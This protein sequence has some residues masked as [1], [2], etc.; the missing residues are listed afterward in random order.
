MT[1]H[2]TVAER[3][4]M[5]RTQL[6]ARGIA[7]ARVLEAM[8]TVPRE[9]FVDE[10]HRASAYQD[11]PL[12]I[13]DGQTISQPYIVALMAE[14]AHIGPTDHVLEV[15]AGS[16][17]ASAVLSRVAGSVV[18]VERHRSLAAGA[19]ARLKALGYSNVAVVHGDGSL[20]CPAHAPFDAIVV[21]AGG[22]DVPQALMEQ[23]RIGGTLVIPVGHDPNTQE[24]LLVRRLGEHRY[25]R[26][27]L[28]SVRFVPLVGAGGWAIDP[29]PSEPAAVSGP[30]QRRNVAA[31]I[32]AHCEPLTDHESVALDELV[33]RVGDARVVLI[34]E[35]THG[36]SE[37]Y[38][39][40][41]RIT[42]E[43]IRQAGFDVVALEADWPDAAVLNRHVNARATGEEC[44]RAFDRFPQWMWR[45]L[46]TAEF[47][48]WL[49]SRHLR[50][51]RSD[52]RVLVCGLDLYGMSKAIASVLEFLDREHP[53]AAK[54][55]RERYACLS[56]WQHD[57]ATYGRATMSGLLETCE[58][59]AVAMLRDMLEL[60]LA[61]PARTGDPLF[62]AQRNAAVVRDAERYYRA[63]YWGSSE[64]WNLRD[65][66]M[67]ST[68]QAVLAH[69]GATSKAV[70][71]AHNSHVGDASA[72]EM[73]ERGETNLGE[74]ARRSWGQGAYL[75]GMG[76]HHGTV[77]A[78]AAW[79]A[80]MR[81]RT[82]LPSHPDSFERLCLDAGVGN[83]MLALR[84]AKGAA[85]R[86]MLEVPRLQRAVGVVY[87][88]ETEFLSHYL[89][90]SVAR[91]FDEWIWFT[92]T[93]AVTA[94][95]GGTEDEDPGTYPF[96][97]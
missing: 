56:P 58:D 47:L 20:G 64:S 91:Q 61:D 87:R 37:F 9:E 8:R 77:A 92:R 54:L 55:A 43:L 13:S 39:M 27:S 45:N 10:R 22:P 18:A 74:L 65:A 15:G 52:R 16:G 12:P 42:R 73:R 88:P 32:A 83:F 36:T 81:V 62:E 85:L 66:H 5:V 30:R 28:G 40:R 97:T 34:G 96:G 94:T 84:H 59:E 86:A 53:A 14:A 90:A 50:L 35:S 38:R 93:S 76:T 33:R 25:E 26:E 44:R 70:V 7:D 21:S 24:L 19:E 17:Y 72:T 68:L 51:D 80:P 82:L 63:I 57:P 1:A 46:E 29:H 89:E 60:R 2:A 4:E 23:L 75:I 48:Q 78:A 6:Q 49:S 79:D 31:A 71:W 41:N 69:R 67:L 3:E 11:A 95:A